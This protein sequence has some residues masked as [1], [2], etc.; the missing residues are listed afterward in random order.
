MMARNT[1]ITREAVFEA[2]DELALHLGKAPTQSQVRDALGGG[3]FSTIGPLVKEWELARSE[4]IDAR[5][6]D[7]PEA[8]QVALAEVAGRLWKVASSEA[9]L[10]VEAARREVEDMKRD[11]LAEAASASEAIR[12]V[13]GERDAALV[14]VD[15]LTADLSAAQAYLAQVQDDLRNQ[16][17]ARV[18]AETQAEAAT[19]R[20]E[21]S[22]ADRKA[23]ADDRAKIEAEA[24]QLREAAVSLREKVSQLTAERAGL[25][26]KVKDATAA[27]AA[28]D[29][30]T[31]KAE[32]RADRAEARAEA[33]Q[34]ELTKTGAELATARADLAKERAEHAG[35]RSQL[36]ERL[37]HLSVEYERAEDLVKALQAKLEANSQIRQPAE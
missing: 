29:V 3:S 14:H 6:T 16:S 13:E 2:A 37:E 31:A 25:A 9:A 17:E 27:T 18:R 35:T 34:I 36:S 30:R 21:R 33:A 26:E 11:A 15:S 5:D 8:V 1:T 28:A 4:Q 7:V 32:A 24:A 22:D 23:M 10:G 12:I 19:A 20:A